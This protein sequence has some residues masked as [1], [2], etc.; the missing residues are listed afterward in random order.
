MDTIT[1]ILDTQQLKLVV[2]V[3]EEL[4]LKHGLLDLL[5]YY[6]KYLMQAEYSKS[7]RMPRMQ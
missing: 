3:A 2:L 4:A 5:F 1:K 7:N 6:F